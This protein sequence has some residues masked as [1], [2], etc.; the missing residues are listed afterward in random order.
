MCTSGDVTFWQTYLL[1]VGLNEEEVTDSEQMSLSFKAKAL[2][3]FC[4][5]SDVDTITRL[6]GI[7]YKEFL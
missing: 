5:I 1:K 3:C 4:A 7:S 2:K 6:T